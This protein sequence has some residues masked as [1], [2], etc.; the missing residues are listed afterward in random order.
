MDLVEIDGLDVHALKA[1]FAGGNDVLRREVA[2][3]IAH[4]VHAARGA[5][6]FG[7]DDQLFAR[8]GV[9][10]DPVANDFFSQVEGLGA[11]WHGVHLGRVD[12]VDTA[13][14]RTAEDGMGRGFIHLFAKHHGAQADGGDVQVAAA[15]LDGFHCKTTCK[16][17]GRFAGVERW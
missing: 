15:E 16:K 6:H 12:E 13:L 2:A 8:T 11:R 5:R 9:G 3:A 7:G 4:P 17:V 14:Q 1:A 10:L